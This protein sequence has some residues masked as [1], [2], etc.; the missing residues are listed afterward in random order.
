MIRFF[1]D[2]PLESRINFNR[3][4]GQARLIRD[5]E[6]HDPSDYPLCGGLPSVFWHDERQEYVMIYTLLEPDEI[7]L[8]I[9]QCAAHS[10]DAVHWE[11]L[12]TRGFADYPDRR[13]FNQVF[14]ECEGEAWVYKDERAVP[15]ERYKLFY[16]RYVFD[17]P[18]EKGEMHV[19]DELFV[20]PDAFHWTKLPGTWNGNGAEPGIGCCYSPLKRSY[21]ISCRPHWCDRRVCIVET[22]DWRHFTE[23]LIAV[24]TDALDPPLAEAYG[25]PIFEIEDRTVGLLWILEEPL[26]ADKAAVGN[27][28]ISAGGRMAPQLVYSDNGVFYLRSL[29]EPFLRQGDPDSPDYGSLF[30]SSLL[31]RNDGTWLITAAASACGHGGFRLRGNGSILTYAMTADRWIYLESNGPGVLQTLDLVI[32]EDMFINAH[33]YGSLRFQLVDHAGTPI[34]GFT[35]KDCDVFCGNDTH[36]V[37]SWDGKTASALLGQVV[38]LQITLD[39]G[40]LYSIGGATV[41]GYSQMRHYLA[42]GETPKEPLIR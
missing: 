23:P 8:G 15:E 10:T 39:G 25:M 35:Y 12:D 18:R 41:I 27:M 38:K 22:K 28:I 11:P 4:L 26:G 3:R 21:I 13:L 34:Q 37:L 20:S 24:Q 7:G 16:F 32:N 29:R 30:A 5:S 14:P 40:R 17:E 42:Y 31:K 33:V 19:S 1:D 2:Q 6:Y 36:R 9:I